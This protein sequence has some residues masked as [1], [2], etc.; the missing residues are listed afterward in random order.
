M[1][2]QACQGV[3]RCAPWTSNLCVPKRSGFACL[4]MRIVAPALPCP[5]CGYPLHTPA[6]TLVVM[7]RVPRLFTTLMRWS[8]SF[9]HFIFDGMAKVPG[10]A[11]TCTS[12]VRNVRAQ[13]G[14]SHWVCEGGAA[15]PSSSRVN[16]LR[17]HPHKHRVT[18]S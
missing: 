17:S 2:L 12:R 4:R 15:C 5:P 7:P 9:Q 14:G 6:D 16:L 13:G 3:A 11:S 18:L 8:R 10:I 1:C